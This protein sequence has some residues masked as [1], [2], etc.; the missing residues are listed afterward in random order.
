MLR[1]WLASTSPRRRD[2]LTAAGI[3]FELCAPGPE[4]ERGGDHDHGE[5]GAPADLA[6]V[7]ARRKALGAAGPGPLGVVL[8]VDTVVD[9]DGR[10]LGKA[11]GEAEARAMLRQLAGRTH[12]VHTAHCLVRGRDGCAFAELAT[13]VVACRQPSDA[14]LDAYLRSGDWRGKAG[15]YGIQDE[16]QRFLVV[17]AGPFDAVVGLHVAAVQRLLAAA[18]EA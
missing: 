15:A 6:V 8:G 12:R 2:L 7:R 10:E 3:A 9:L 5:T 17:A 11:R 16:T 1:L 13:A 14:E 18:E 4:Y